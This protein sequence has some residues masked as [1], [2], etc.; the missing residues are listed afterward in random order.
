MSSNCKHF[1]LIDWL[2]CDEER[3]FI[4][5]LTVFLMAFTIDVFL[6]EHCRTRSWF[7]I[8]SFIV[9]KKSTA[10]YFVLNSQPSEI[11]DLHSMEIS[12]LYLLNYGE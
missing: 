4:I 11:A 7:M 3:G 5:F 12:D 10:P 9:K 8:N 6:L 2:S 1:E